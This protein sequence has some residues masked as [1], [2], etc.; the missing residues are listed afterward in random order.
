[1]TEK[2]QA[3]EDFRWEQHELRVTY[4]TRKFSVHYGYK[5]YNHVQVRLEDSGEVYLSSYDAARHPSRTVAACVPFHVFAER[6]PAFIAQLQ[7][8]A[9][10]AKEP[11]A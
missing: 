3:G 10:D 2:I 6:L 7:A 9:A 8:I 11:T 1:M 5:Q 4:P